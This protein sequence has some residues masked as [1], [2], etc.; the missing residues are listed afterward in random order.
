MKKRSFWLAVGIVVSL[1]LVGAIVYLVVSKRSS[2][3]KTDPTGS[4]SSIA[5]MTDMQQ[6]SSDDKLII[7]DPN[8]PVTIVE[9]GDFKCPSCN[10]FYRG[11]L[12]DIKKNYIDTGQ[13]K[14]EF[15]NLPYINLDSRTAAEGAYCANAHGKFEAYH[16]GAF[17]YIW[18]NYYRDN[19]ITE[20]E[21]NDVFNPQSLSAIA[22]QAGIDINAFA[23]CLAQ[24]T[25]RDN[26]NADLSASER[27]HVTGTPTIF[28]SNQK[29]IGAQPYTV[30]S[31]LIEQELR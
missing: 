5:S 14:L 28:V 26:V 20:G 25:F 11:A 24:R 17:D 18:D 27:D 22:A 1:A 6:P 9:Y 7:G 15:R 23:D 10:K 3:D 4:D 31:T 8:A 13:V 29:I 2:S 21:S 19:K 30:Y 16:N 12:R